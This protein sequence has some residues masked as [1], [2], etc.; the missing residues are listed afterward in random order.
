MV[1]VRRGKRGAHSSNISPSQECHF[2]MARESW[3]P[4]WPQGASGWRKDNFLGQLRWS[5]CNPKHAPWMAV[6]KERKAPTSRR[7]REFMPCLGCWCRSRPDTER[8]GISVET[9]H[10]CGASSRQVNWRRHYLMS[11]RTATQMGHCF[12]KLLCEDPACG[13]APLNICWYLGACILERRPQPC[14][15]LL[16][17]LLWVDDE[18]LLFCPDIYR[19][20]S[21]GI[22][23]QAASHCVWISAELFFWANTDGG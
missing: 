5:V 20:K 16:F 9:L 11:S 3:T 8:C 10:P 15:A 2:V 6:R 18:S 13:K 21:S 1:W 14:K 23:I 12:W 19:A 7:V 22:L 4:R 17:F